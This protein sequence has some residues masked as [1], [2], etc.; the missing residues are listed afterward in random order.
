[1]GIVLKPRDEASSSRKGKGKATVPSGHVI[2]VDGREQCEFQPSI[3]NH[4]AGPDP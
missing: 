3:H 2:F 1:M 4:R